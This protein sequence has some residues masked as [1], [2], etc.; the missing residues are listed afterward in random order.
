MTFSRHR[1]DK[2]VL[3]AYLRTRDLDLV[4]QRKNI[5]KYSGHVSDLLT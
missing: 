1:G 5:K 4:P 2:H 3:F